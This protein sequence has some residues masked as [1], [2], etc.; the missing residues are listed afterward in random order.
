MRLVCM[1]F[2]FENNWGRTDRPTDGRTDTPSYRDATAHLK[3]G[4]AFPLFFFLHFLF[5]RFFF[6]HFPLFYPLSPLFLPPPSSS[7]SSFFSSFSCSSTSSSPQDAVDELIENRSLLEEVGASLKKLPDLERLLSRIHAMGSKTR[8][9]NH[10]DGRAVI[11][12][13][14]IFDKRKIDDFVKVHY[15]MGQNQVILRHQKFTF[16]RA[17]T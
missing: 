2:T 17:S 3:T 10:P 1:Y 11:F 16:P 6:L 9:E 7:S 14:D 8:H 15:T 13:A 4:F 12:E 5:F